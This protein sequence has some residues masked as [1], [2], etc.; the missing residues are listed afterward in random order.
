MEESAES[1]LQ[2]L[3]LNKNDWLLVF[4]NADGDPNL[5]TRF[6]PSTLQGNVLLTSRN[7]DMRRLAPQ[8]FDEVQE[9]EK[10]DAIS[11]LLNAA[12]LDST[13]DELRQA[14]TPVV[15]ELCCL[16]LAV[17]QAGAAIATG[18]CTIHD[19]LH[20]Y[21]N[22]RQSLM[23]HPSFKGASNYGRAVYATWDLSFNAIIERASGTSDI[24]DAEAAQN[25]IVILQIFAFFHHEN[26]T[27][28]IF[29]NAAHAVHRNDVGSSE[30]LVSIASGKLLPLDKNGQWDPLLFREAIHILQSFSLVKRVVSGF[31]H[32]VH[33]LV[34]TWSRDRMSYE[35]QQMIFCSA[36]ALLT[37]SITYEDHSSDHYFR[38]T[39]TPSYSKLQKEWLL[40]WDYRQLTMKRSL[41]N[42]H[43]FSMKM[44]NG[45]MQKSYGSKYIMKE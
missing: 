8:A 26:I 41:I 39:I 3:C 5:L 16:P 12:F 4:D 34:H 24:M 21:A 27:E 11:L 32:D 23:T 17:D 30:Q 6:I 37:H 36:K 14:A 22:H 29:Q 15:T 31:S 20:M 18:L 25:A 9:M 7:P 2:W 1:V 38:K 33:P 43:L 45:R 13:S 40:K 10:N 28:K 19:Y 42:L 44:V 35:D